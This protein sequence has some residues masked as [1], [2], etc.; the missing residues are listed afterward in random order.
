MSG[1]HGMRGRRLEV[2]G[3]YHGPVWG[4]LPPAYPTEQAERV[5][6]YLLEQMP[7]ESTSRALMGHGFKG[8]AYRFRATTDY[9]SEFENSFLAPGGVAPPVDDHY[10]QERALFGFF[11]S[12]LACLESFAFALHAIAAY[13]RP[14]SFGLSDGHLRA[15]GPKAVADALQSAWPGALVSRITN[16]LVKDDTFRTWKDI[17][18]VLGHRVVPPRHITASPGSGIRSTWGLANQ[19]LDR[20][21]PLEAVARP[22]SL[23]LTERVRDLWDGAEQ[24]FPPT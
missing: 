15:I 22:R 24:S 14:E 6:R 20:D 13:Y 12:G 21:E 3:D 2:T 11:V 23:W 8:V 17:R 1:S 4:S 18:N 5:Y 7:A 19:F 9:A 16:E 10:R